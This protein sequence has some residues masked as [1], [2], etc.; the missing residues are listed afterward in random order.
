VRTTFNKE[1]LAGLKLETK[2]YRNKGDA[3]YIKPFDLD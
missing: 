2:N 3:S 1:S